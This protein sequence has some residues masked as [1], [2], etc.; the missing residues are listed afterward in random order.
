M[1]IFVLDKDPKIAAQYLCDKHI[2]KMILES[3]QLLCSQFECDA[4]Y[5]KTH[6]NHPCSIWTRT[7][8]EN[9]LW[10]IEHSLEMGL[11]YTKR[12]NKTHKSIKVIRWT[13]ENIN[14]V[15]FIN[16]TTE[17]TNFAL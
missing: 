1:N 12:Y 8:K 17:L 9:Y 5:K 6:Y 11:E 2:V 3:A 7:S 14:K 10:L 15:K 13:Q 16:S 4:P